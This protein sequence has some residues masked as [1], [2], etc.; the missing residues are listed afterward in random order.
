MDAVVQARSTVG[1]DTIRVAPGDYPEQVGLTNSADSGDV[2]DGAGTAINPVFGTTINPEI[3][4][5][6]SC[7]AAAL[8][9]ASPVLNSLTLRDVRLHVTRP[10]G[11]T[12]TDKGGI[13]VNATSSA[14]RNVHVDMDSATG[15][16]VPAVIV[17]AGPTTIDGLTNGGVWGSRGLQLSLDEGEQATVR[18][19][20]ITGP[21]AVAEPALGVGGEGNVVVQ[22]TRLR[23]STTGGGNVLD[24][25]AP[26]YLRVESSLITGGRTG[27]L[28]DGFSG[29][30][31]SQTTLRN[32]TVD[33]GSQK[34][35]DGGSARAISASASGGG[36][37]V[38]VDFNSSIALERVQAQ[39]GNGGSSAVDC[40]FSDVRFQSQAPTAFQGA[41]NCGNASG[42][43]Q[44]TPAA[45]FMPGIT[46]WRPL[47]PGSPA[48][49][50][51]SPAG[52]LFGESTTDLAGSPRIL[53]GNRDCLARR[54]KGAYEVTGHGCPLPTRPPA[55]GSAVL[56]GNLTIGFKGGRIPFRVSCPGDVA[57]VDGILT[58]KTAKP[59]S[60]PRSAKRRRVIKLADAT[61]SIPAGAT[62]T[63][64]AKLTK[65]GKRLFRARR[66]V[67]ADA[68]LQVGD[69]P[70]TSERVKLK[71]K[72]RKHP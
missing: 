23:R 51:G 41:I 15:L 17:G 59:L 3:P 33:V 60:L 16:E 24:A 38:T 14:I 40:T 29:T 5:V 26:D 10:A 61:F 45:L 56:G 62:E 47:V 21:T 44:S 34:G 53:D 12:S 18:D 55:L 50:T 32:T 28:V 57:C 19:S 48:I 27:V 42:N 66:K 25:V 49:D 35:N 39:A 30:G 8:G 31:S 64:R 65:R 2:I 70:V 20:D 63:V 13:V 72:R 58:A 6:G 43:S 11:A 4:D 37:D 71:R 68:E 7:C 22:R 69:G 1:G 9:G 36:T 67:K 54:D 46:D 52:L